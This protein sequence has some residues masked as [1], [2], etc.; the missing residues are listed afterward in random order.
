M[1][2]LGNLPGLNLQ[3]P[4]GSPLIKKVEE[5]PQANPTPP[6]SDIDAERQ[7]EARSEMG[8]KTDEAIAQSQENVQAIST[9]YNEALK[10]GDINRAQQLQT[11]LQ[12][13]QTDL[14]NKMML[15]KAVEDEDKFTLQDLAL[16][17]LSAG[18]GMNIW[19]EVD[20]T[21]NGDDDGEATKSF[22]E[23]F[24]ERTDVMTDPG[25]RQA[26][27]NASYGDQSA[28]RDLENL[29][30]FGTTFGSLSNDM[31][32]GQYGESL[33]TAYQEFIG[34][35]DANG[36]SINA[37]ID[38]DQFLVEWARQNPTNPI[39][40]EIQQKLSRVGQLERSSR[41]LGQIDRNLIQEG[42]QDA[43]NFYKP[44]S[45][46]GMG[47]TPDQFRSPEQTAMVNEAMG[48]V[49]DPSQQLLEQR[50]TDRV[51]SNGRLDQATLRTITDDAL[52]STGYFAD[53]PYLKGGGASQA[54]L[55]TGME[56]D[57]RMSRD[58]NSL[59]SLL[60]GQRQ[61]IPSAT[62][63]VT[64]N[65]VDPIKA[66]GL[67]GSNTN[68]ANNMYQTNPVQGLN[69]NP[70]AIPYQ[71]QGSTPTQTAGDSL[72]SI[73]NDLLTISNN[74]KQSGNQQSDMFAYLTGK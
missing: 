33:E 17:T 15:R 43:S 29:S 20:K 21:L 71:S 37:Q 59:F 23:Q 22:T 55:N 41:E 3:S 47:F 13:A 64:Q 72:T 8:T 28:L 60:Q 69:F 27:I 39:S 16:L 4:N 53:Q 25:L 10:T 31:F 58:E 49:N 57:R 26:I 54:I 11:M 36:N 67:S 40:Q 46:G 62:N 1:T 5:Q 32:N 70:G 48:L 44:T 56:M 63:I 65:T 51:N 2:T 38:R 18:A 74:N 7:A 34:A 19:S 45:M 66:L 73:G 9:Q 42:F 52:G 35:K 12:T 24:M 30:S 61:Y 14:Q 50:L 6:P 68:T